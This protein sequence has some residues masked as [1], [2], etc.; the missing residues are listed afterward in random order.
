MIHSSK[1]NIITEKKDGSGKALPFDFKAVTLEGEIIEGNNCIVT[2]SHHAGRTRN[3]KYPDSN[4]F[5]K[6]RNISFIE[7]NGVEVTM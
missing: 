4:E 6:L 1:I 7:L 2:S 3:I 5:R